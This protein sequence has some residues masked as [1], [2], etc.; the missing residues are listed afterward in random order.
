MTG[1]QEANNTKPRR[2][3]QQ[4]RTAQAE[5]AL[6]DAA[7]T[8]F[9]RRGVERT[10]LA[11][12]GVHAGY[13]RGLVNHHFGSKAALV[14]RLA[15]DIQEEFVREIISRIDE[16]DDDAVEI[17]AGMVGDYLNGLVEHEETARAFFVMWSAA[18]PRE[19]AL[20]PV[21]APDD[22][23]FRLGVEGVLRNGQKQG[24]VDPALD[25]AATAL[26]IVGLLRGVV[27][28][29]LVTPATYDL[30]AAIESSRRFVRRGLSPERQGRE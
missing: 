26:T 6:L 7:A 23:R 8:L 22:A 10:S 1:G 29:Y 4:E 21:M 28:Q 25:P 11:D 2:R 17:I 13:S 19:A 24:S 18:I 5:R 30:A 16:S 15:R 27:A 14:E 20:R 12:V 3:T 9:A